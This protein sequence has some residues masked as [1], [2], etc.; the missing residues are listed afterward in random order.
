[1]WRN[2]DVISEDH[3]Y[4]LERRYDNLFG[5][6]NQRFRCYGLVYEPSIDPEFND[7]T[8]NVSLNVIEGSK[9]L[10]ELKGVQAVDRLGHL[11]R[12]SA[13]RQFE[14]E[15]TADNRLADGA[16]LLFVHSRSGAGY[17]DGESSEI[18]GGVTLY[19]TPYDISTS[20]KGL[21]GVALCRFRIEEKRIAIDEGFVPLGVFVDSSR[22]SERRHSELLLG[23]ENLANLLGRYVGSYRPDASTS[24]AWSFAASL[25]RIVTAS[26]R[27]LRQKQLPVHR[28]FAVL[29]QLKDLCRVEL[30]LFSLSSSDSLAQRAK[31]AAGFISTDLVWDLSET[32]DL[33]PIFD[34]AEQ[35][36]RRII[37]F[38]QFLPH[39]VVV[40]ANIPISNVQLTREPGGNKLL[41]TFEKPT[42]LVRGE[43]LLTITLRE[44]SNS[45]PVHTRLRVGLGDAIFAQLRELEGL[46]GRVD[47]DARTYQI[48]VPPEVITKEAASQ[49]TIYLPPPM[50]EGVQPLKHHMAVTCVVKP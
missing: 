11:I 20:S 46:L 43:S 6:V 5:S 19:E 29:D 25:W 47:P 22:Q 39:G 42:T 30:V 18:R 34:R 14:L 40:E 38:L 49:I 48:K 16:Y 41:I 28:F 8:K 21:K 3:F 27:E 36:V 23:L 24:S 32:A 9:I 4:A 31:G 17:T 44:F 7:L 35:L 10:V 45:E 37:E 12:V 33:G 2:G 15:L 13:A 26:T 1:L 50:G